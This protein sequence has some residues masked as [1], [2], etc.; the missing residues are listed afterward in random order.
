VIR[1]SNVK[2]A[3]VDCI[4]EGRKDPFRLHAER[5]K[6]K[7][8]SSMGQTPNTL[9]VSLYGISEQDAGKAISKAHTI[10]IIA[11]SEGYSGFIGSGQ[12]V[13]ARNVDSP[14]GYALNIT[15]IDGDDFYSKPVNRSI[16]GGT[17]LKTLVEELVGLSSGTVGVGQISKRASGIVLPRGQAIIGTAIPVIRSVAKQINAAF[18]INQ[19]LV[20]IVCPDEM[21]GNPV[22]LKEEDMA[23]IPTKDGYY[24]VFEYDINSGIRVGNSVVVPGGDTGSG[25]YRVVRIV[26]E[27]DTD[28]PLWKMTVEGAEQNESGLAQEAV[29][30]NVWR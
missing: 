5:V 30:R 27:G 1:V 19:G 3:Y 26:T 12:V 8:V 10:S 25:L 23:G 2:V 18:Y 7:V 22:I 24:V 15:A 13:M 16:S 17:S 29:T 28:G 4:D 6:F 14:E 9:S 21:I 20:Y 11:G